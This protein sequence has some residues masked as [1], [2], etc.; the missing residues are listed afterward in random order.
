[1]KRVAIQFAFF[2][3]F[4]TLILQCAASLTKSGID[5]FESEDYDLAKEKL[6]L[7]LQENP[8]NADA[9][10][11][12]GR[13]AQ[14]SGDFITMKKYYDTT[15]Q[16]QEGETS[17]SAQLRMLEINNAL[18]FAY[19]TLFNEGYDYHSAGD[20]L[21][22]I[23]EEQSNVSYEKGIEKFKS[24]SQMTDLAQP[25]ELLAAS[26]LKLKNDEEA[27]KYLTIVLEK[28][29]D[30]FLS[31]YN[32]AGI[33]LRAVEQDESNQTALLSQALELYKRIVDANSDELP[34]ILIQLDFVFEKLGKHGKAVEYYNQ[35]LEQ[36]PENVDLLSNLG[37]SLLAT[38]D[39]A[40][41]RKMFSTVIE[42]DPNSPETAKRVAYSVWNSY[43]EKINSGEQL[44][45]EEIN[46]VL[47]F[48][49]RVIELDSTDIIAWESLMRLYAQLE[50]LGKE[51]VSDKLRNAMEKFQEISEI[52]NK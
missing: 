2:I 50:R 40:G 33:K 46:S 16:I 7:A 45:E 28:D 23:N 35:Y 4:S 47:P 29:P 39:T 27:E 24:A 30:S 9:H 6:M 52:I 25:L 15:R 8:L 5:D 21:L 19:V 34:M 31:L 38:G 36:F 17:G 49:E 13:I 51:D 26:Y 10:F 48:M 37:K 22:T 18:N 20:S 11:Y 42:I 14:E 41:A 43:V 1:M 32:L 44:S 12:L 3:V